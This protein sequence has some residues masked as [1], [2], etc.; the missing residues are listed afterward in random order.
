MSPSERTRPLLAVPARVV[1]GA[2]R[3][4]SRHRSLLSCL[5]LLLTLVVGTV[6]L[7][8]GALG[9]DP[10]AATMTVRVHLAQSGG[11]LAGQNVTLRGVPI[12]RVESVELTPTGLVATAAIDATVRVPAD[13]G[14]RV[15]SLSLAGEQYLDFRPAGDNGP[16]LT[17][18]AEIEVE[19]TSTP[20]P[21]WQT[22]AQLD[23]T[24]AQVDPARL[25][26][27]VEELGVSAHGPGK[28]ADI[29]DGGIFLVS[30]LDSVLPQT[31]GL[32]RDSRTVLTTAA[33][34]APGLGEF[35]GDAARL[36][37]GVEA[38]TGGFV[39]LL[40]AAPGTLAALDA[41]MAQNSPAVVDLIGNLGTVADMANSRVPALREFFF[42]T[43]RAGSTLGNLT[44]AFHDGGLWGLVNLYPRYS[45]DY[46]LPR[47]P[48]ARPDFPEP[49]IYTHCAN[50][51][52]SVLIRG[53]RNAPRP[54]GARVPGAPPPGQAADTQAIPTPLGPW[55]IPLTFA[56]PE[57]PT[58][59]PR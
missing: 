58:P 52:P 5:A 27:I 18:G 24:L 49:Y 15:A 13:G 9:V 43:E 50:E 20:V 21:L 37:S 39:D 38:K 22:L 51:D 54:P 55:S 46:N 17:D 59:V 56:G 26:A 53:A 47:H 8:F 16:Y 40:G 11:L 14:V 33:A 36:M 1:V 6:Y 2:A 3:L 7:V 23:T 10:T 48:P 31:V 32:L 29:I 44:A 41:V 12:G 35:A 34:A 19:R 25:A 4:G 28:L 42:P 30:T 45:C 57:L